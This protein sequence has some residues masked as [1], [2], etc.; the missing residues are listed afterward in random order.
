VQDVSQ[1]EFIKSLVP[2]RDLL[3]EN[4]LPPGRIR[5]VAAWNHQRG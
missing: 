2:T 5:N 3:L 1:I 4:H